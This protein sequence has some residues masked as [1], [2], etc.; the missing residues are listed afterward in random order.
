MYIF[1]SFMSAYLESS[2]SCEQDRVAG[3]TSE[4]V[5]ANIAYLAAERTSYLGPT[6]IHATVL[7]QR[8]SL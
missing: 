4:L 7:L 3:S 8:N 6:N 2:S 1:L 5:N